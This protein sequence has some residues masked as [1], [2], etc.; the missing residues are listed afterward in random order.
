MYGV[1]EISR[2]SSGDDASVKPRDRVCC[3]AGVRLAEIER[4][5]A[6]CEIHV[7]ANRTRLKRARR[8]N[9][10]LKP[11]L[12]ERWVLTRLH[13]HRSNRLE[14]AR[15]KRR[16]AEL[17]SCFVVRIDDVHL[18]ID[19]STRRSDDRIQP[20]VE[21]GPLIWRC[22]RVPAAGGEASGQG[23]DSNTGPGA[24]AIHVRPPYLSVY[25]CY[26]FRSCA[27]HESWDP[28]RASQAIAL[29]WPSCLF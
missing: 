16:P 26:T 8:A 1:G 7:E 27:A 3:D 12:I 14:H 22:A 4:L 10:P 23:G 6:S 17:Q 11:V 19:R 2:F 28:F 25:P 29:E 20:L 13:T 9:G 21:D 18:H 24:S 5:L 15:F